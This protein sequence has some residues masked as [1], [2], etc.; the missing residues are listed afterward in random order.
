[1][2]V[3]LKLKYL[4]KKIFFSGIIL[5]L[6][7]EIMAQGGNTAYDFLNIPSSSYVFGMGGVNV[8]DLHSDIDM[9]SE[10]PSLIGPENDKELKLGYMH[11]YGNSNFASVR[12]GQAAGEHGAWVAGIRYLNYGNFQGYESNGV[13]TGSFTVQDIVA[14]GSYAHDFT[15]RLRG[16]INV[17]MIYSVYEQYS[18]FAMAADI[19]LNYYDETKDLSLGFVLKNMGG[20]IKRFEDTYN[21]L[22][23][24]I[25]LGLTKGFKENFSFSITAWNLTKWKLPYYIHENGSEVEMSN[26]GFF[27]NFFSHF[28]FGV[29]YAPV[30]KF[31]ATLG[32]NYRTASNMTSYER[33]ILSGFS[34]GAGFKVKAFSVGAAYAIPHKKASTILLNLGVDIFEML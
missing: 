28:V 29:S 33:N 31:Y 18:A 12:Y 27:R 34:I 7:C 16:G 30:D 1:M 23:F 4:I 9:V 22:P 6:P 3:H 19:G 13:A 2:K 14:E 15:Y 24:D 32:Y 5:A 20:Q 26:P 25:E 8:S 17:K 11:Y 10:N 21:R